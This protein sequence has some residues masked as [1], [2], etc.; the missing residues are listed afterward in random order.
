MT[1]RAF[2]WDQMGLLAEHYDVAVA[3]DWGAE[4]PPAPGSLGDVRFLSLPICR[5]ISPHRDARTL[6]QL[7]ILF[8]RERF[9]AVHSV[10][11]KAGLLA[12]SAA[13]MSR[14]PVRVHMFTG[15]VWATRRGAGRFALKQVDRFFARQATEVLVDSPSQR[16]FLV[17]EGV[18]DERGSAVLADGSICGV[19][20]ERFR[21]DDEARRRVRADLGIA[22]DALVLLFLG[23]LNPD[24][25]VLDLAEAFAHETLHEKRVLLFVGP[26]EAG[27]M[28]QIRRRTQRVTE[29]VLFV[30]YTRHPERYMAAADVFCL[31]S[32]REGFGTVIIEAAAC[33]VPALASRIYGLTDAVEDGATGMLH[34]PRD[35][36]DLTAKMDHLLQDE[37]SRKAMGEKARQRALERFPKDRLSA[38]L[39]ARYE[40]ALGE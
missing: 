12:M 23:R 1:V 7:V 31:P 25:G 15:Q 33:R 27:M 38:A 29:R 24:K 37:P 3:T 39:L 18:V 5:G 16:D 35:V 2:L 14:I 21:P 9:D 34:E 19:D 28:R 11:P 36:A 22:H 8:R 40:C 13:R 17:K 32:Y 10:T 30:G 6:A 26:D 4:G 20:T